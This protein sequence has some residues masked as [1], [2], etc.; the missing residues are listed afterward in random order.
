MKYECVVGM[1]VHCR[2]STKTKL[3]CSCDNS[4]TLEP[5]THVCPGCLGMPGML[6]VLN[7]AAMEYGIKAALALNCEI[8]ES[9][10]F[11]RKHYFYPDLPA[12]FQ[13]SQL[14]RAVGHRG[15]LLVPNEEGR[16]RVGI[17]RVQVE[18]DA[19]KLVHG[20]GYSAVD[21]NRAGSPLIEIVSEPDMRSA[22]EARAYLELLRQTL[23]Y[24]GVTT[25]NMEEGALRFDANVS[26]RP[27]GSDKM[28]VR[29]EI[30]NLNTFKGVE[31][32]I[33]LMVEDLIRR[34]EEGDTIRQLTWGYSLAKNRI[35]PM[36]TKETAADYRYSA[37]PDIPII[38]IPAEMVAAVRETLPE[39]P[40]AK[41]NRLATDYGLGVYEARILASEAAMADYFEALVRMDV[42]ARE[43]AN[44]MLNEVARALNDRNIGIADFPV[45]SKVMADLINLAVNKKISLPAA[46]AILEK[47]LAGDKASPADIVSRDN[48]GQVSDAGA[49]KEQLENIIAASP[50]QALEIQNGKTATAMWFVGQVMKAMKG[51]ANPAVVTAAIAERFGIDAAFFQKKLNKSDDS[52]KI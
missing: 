17:N 25:G 31:S 50:K 10:R 41:E 16:R 15:Y 36:R 48:L 4:F 49:V 1:E 46:K 29:N 37:A 24:C 6:P 38:P 51:K 18:E 27:V 3:F 22:A 23:L 21:L 14:Q 19:G 47:L 45:S 28:G 34:I 13:V 9:C 40:V 30:K 44:W 11:E 26:V 35:Y 12:G 7:R 52:D 2:L 8:S 39:L 42:P 33:N 43:A 20:A 32:A 5:N